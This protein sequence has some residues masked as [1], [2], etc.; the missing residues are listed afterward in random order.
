MAFKSG[1]FADLLIIISLVNLRPVEG[2]L[3][4]IP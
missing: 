4:S 2:A 1:A 3:T